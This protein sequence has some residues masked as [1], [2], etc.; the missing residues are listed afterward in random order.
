MRYT[1]DRF[2]GKFAVCE[3]EN[4]SMINIPKVAL[5]DNCVKGDVIVVSID[6][7]ETQNREERINKLMTD[8][9]ND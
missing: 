2:E 5:P 6:R 1:I 9:F 3:L 8:L 4:R 7:K